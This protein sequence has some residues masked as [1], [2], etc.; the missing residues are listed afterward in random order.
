MT[1]TQNAWQPTSEESRTLLAEFGI[2]TPRQVAVTSVDQVLDAAGSFDGP[3]VIKAIAPDLV[4]KSDAGGVV[5]GIRSPE[6]AREE[7]LEMA[8]RIPAI[9]GFLMQEFVAGSHEIF[10]GMRRDPVLGAFVLVGLGGIWVEVLN[11]VAIRPVPCTEIDAETMLRSLRAAPLLAGGRGTTA[12]DR[13][14]IAQVVVS[15]SQ[16]AAQHPEIE[17]LDLNPVVVADGMAIAVDWH[18]LCRDPSEAIP[19]RSDHR[20]VRH[21]L[22]PN[23]IVVVGA[24]ADTDKVGGRLFRYLVSHGYEKPLYAVNSDAE[25]VMG[26]P[27]YHS[28]SKLPSTPDLA[29]VVVPVSSVLKVARECAE[30]GIPGIIVYSSGFAE[31]GPEGRHLQDQLRELATESGVLISGPNTAGMINTHLPMCASIT[32]ASEDARMP[33][34]NIGVITQSGGLGSALVSRI[35]DSGAAISTWVSCGNEVDLTLSDYLDH[36]VDDER[37]DVVVLFIEAL[38]EVEIFAAACRR[39][40][41]LG[42]PILAYKTGTTEL[43][44]A[45]VCS[46]TAALAGDDQLYDATF[47]SLGVIRCHDLQS[48]LDA[49]IAL[50]WQPIPRANRVAVISTSGGACSIAADACVRAGLELPS[51]SEKA[52]SKIRTA[53]P[54]FGSHANPVDV[55]LGASTHPQIVG[56]AVAAVMDESNIDAIL[57]AL[58]SNTGKPALHMARH[59]VSLTERVDK[60]LI[61]ARVAADYLA[62]DALAHYREGQVP[63]YSTPERAVAVLAAMVEAGKAR[64]VASTAARSPC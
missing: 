64:E 60:P 29:C 19:R 47:R 56:D 38:R 5:V 57:V 6:S 15:V 44:R 41:V 49:A 54:S 58:S 35:W 11:D 46:H 12:V 59:L 33:A 39:A 9:T 45:A 40:R 4:H 20:G 24:S 55:T 61:V 62:T 34:G 28:V 31:S 36:L 17:Q 23:G 16:F 8:A 63:V 42:K 18:L 10:L 13:S 3:I 2:A 27:A 37:T 26:R 32:M 51:F 30:A 25:P 52:R 43:G 21:I 22:S 7:A 53:I 50:S 1:V 14:A 48:L